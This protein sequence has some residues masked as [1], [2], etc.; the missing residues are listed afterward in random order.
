V[1]Q[2]ITDRLQERYDDHLAY[3]VTCMLF[4]QAVRCHFHIHV[5]D[6]SG[7]ENSCV[8]EVNRILGVANAERAYAD[9]GVSP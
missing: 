4:D 1:S 2:L 8:S 5:R 9:L 6:G 7:R 3:I